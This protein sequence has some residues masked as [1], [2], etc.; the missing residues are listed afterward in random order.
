M[1]LLV[2]VDSF[3]SF[4]LLPLTSSPRSIRRFVLNY[5]GTTHKDGFIAAHTIYIW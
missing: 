2:A 5:Q 3:Q 1:P 4:W